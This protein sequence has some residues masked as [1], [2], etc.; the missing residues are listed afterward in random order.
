[1]EATLADNKVTRSHKRPKR[2]LFPQVKG[3]IVE[4]VEIKPTDSGYGIGFMFPDRTYLNFD[5]EACFTI[6]PDLSD[7]KTKNYKPLK[8]WP[9]I[10]SKSSRL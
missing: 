5:V 8:R 1:M 2:P 10:H 3:K 7:W 9:A 6:A 4:D